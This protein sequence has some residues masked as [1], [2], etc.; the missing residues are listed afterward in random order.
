MGRPKDFVSEDGNVVEL[1]LA[2]MKPFATK[3]CVGGLRYTS[4]NMKTGI[5]VALM[6]MWALMFSALM[7]LDPRGG[8][9]LRMILKQL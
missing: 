8:T 2:A 7:K 9:L 5:N 1:L 4:E 6:S 3:L